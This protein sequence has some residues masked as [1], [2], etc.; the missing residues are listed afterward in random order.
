M[1]TSIK[2][3]TIIDGRVVL[4]NISEPERTLETRLSILTYKVG[5]L[6][7]NLVKWKTLESKA[8]KLEFKS[9]LAQALCHCITI[10]MSQGWDVSELVD[11]GWEY[12]GDRF[13]DFKKN[14]E[15]KEG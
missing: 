1:Q 4:G 12:I 10:A 8:H 11:L 14:W 3:P 5:N 15:W 13:K 2:L 9:N 7:E 6:H